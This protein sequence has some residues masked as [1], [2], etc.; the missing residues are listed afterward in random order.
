LK[1][2]V[3][4]PF[5]QS[6][7]LD[8]WRKKICEVVTS[9]GHLVIDLNPSS[10]FPLEYFQ[11]ADLSSPIKNHAEMNEST[12][13]QIEDIRFNEGL[14]ERLRITAELA[15]RIIP[16]RVWRAMVPLRRKVLG[17][18][19]RI[20]RYLPGKKVKLYSDSDAP[21]T[22]NDVYQQIKLT[23]LLEKNVDLVLFTYFDGMDDSTLKSWNKLEISL[24]TRM[25]IIVFK[26][27][28]SIELALKSS[29]SVSSIA[30]VDVHNFNILSQFQTGVD[31]VLLPD[32]PSLNL[33]NRDC[34]RE[35]N[36]LFN[37][38]KKVVGVIGSIDWRKNLDLFLASA[39]SEAGLNYN[40]LIVGKIYYEKMNVRTILLIKESLEGKHP[41]IL[42]IPDFQNEENFKRMYG[43][44]DVHFLMYLNWNSASNALTNVITNRGV[45]LLNI[46]SPFFGSVAKSGLGIP[47]IDTIEGVFDGIQK[48]DTFQVNEESRSAYLNQNCEE[49]FELKLDKLIG[50][51]NNE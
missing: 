40:W 10:F 21:L 26:V 39:T 1:I 41:N 22:F 47:T 49:N 32:F 43:M 30:T 17:V 18:I 23:L 34:N 24:N 8:S 45:A 4:T 19:F 33:P 5:T 9:R 27:T 6:G 25:A 2:L 11:N 20:D 12:R 31:I 38:S 3:F 50:L 14:R 7:H 48:S 16:K 15:K 36:P 51:K 13:E 37:N 35:D 42:V 28:P 44:I 29:N 46:N